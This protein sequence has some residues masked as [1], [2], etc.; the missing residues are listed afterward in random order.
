MKPL[1]FERSAETQEIIRLGIFPIGTTDPP[2]GRIILPGQQG[3]QTQE[4]KRVH[5]PGIE[6]KNAPA[7]K[8]R[9]QVTSGPHVLDGSL[10]ENCHAARAGIV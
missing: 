9:I 7:A 1:L 6:L 3:K 2:D 5:M 4:L 8:L 10:V